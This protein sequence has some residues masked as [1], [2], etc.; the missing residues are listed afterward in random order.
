MVYDQ[1]NYRLITDQ[2]LSDHKQITDNNR[3]Q[4]LDDAFVLAS[5]HKVSYQI[6]LD[7]S[8]YLEKETE[9]V[10]WNAVLAEFNYIDTMLH[11]VQEYPDW[12]VMIPFHSVCSKIIENG[13]RVV[14]AIRISPKP[15]V[16]DMLGS[17]PF[18]P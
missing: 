15:E 10:P 4:L 3:A 14:S 13:R 1:L 5:A 12:K 16:V 9:Y 7:L 2:L 11:N 17:S 8:L 6:A 18:H